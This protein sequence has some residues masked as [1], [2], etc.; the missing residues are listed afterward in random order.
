MPSIAVCPNADVPVDLVNN[1][2]GFDSE[3]GAISFLVEQYLSKATGRL[4]AGMRLKE[5]DEAVRKAKSNCID[6]HF[7]D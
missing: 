5:V 1:L 6:E 4:D 2:K 3:L 7:G